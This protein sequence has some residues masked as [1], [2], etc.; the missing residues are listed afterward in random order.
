MVIT[1]ISQNNLLFVVARGL[2]LIRLPRVAVHIHTLLARASDFTAG[3]LSLPPDKLRVA[4]AVACV[5]YMAHV[6]C[7]ALCLIGRSEQARGGD[8]WIDVNDFA[9]LPALSIYLRGYFWAIYTIVTVGFG[10]VAIAT[11]AERVFAMSVMIV[12]AIMCDAGITAMLSSI[13]ASADK[14]SGE[15]RRSK[16]AMLQFCHSQGYSDD[17]SS[18]VALYYDYVSTDL[19]NS[20]EDKDFALLPAALQVEFVQLHCFDAL[21]SLCLLD[22][23]QVEV[24]LGFVYSV[25]RHVQLAIAIPGQVL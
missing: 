5:C 10:S 8:N 7:C 22:C 21:C 14:L 9:N 25:L 23:E 16:E 13:I 2:Y 24:R 1:G 3:R 20:V 15:T 17:I 4:A 18:K 19:Q 6:T 11:S 12:G